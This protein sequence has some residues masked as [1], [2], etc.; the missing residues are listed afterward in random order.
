MKAFLI[1]PVAESI[2]EVEYS[3]EYQDIYPLIGAETFDVVTL[4]PNDDSAFIDDEGLL[5]S[6][7]FF[8]FHRNRRDPVAGCGLVLGVDGEGDSI[9]PTVSRE[10]LA[11]DI[12]FANHDDVR[13]VLA[14]QEEISSVFRT[15]FEEVA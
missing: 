12:V 7:E 5:K 9:A 13:A 2:T 8:W 1:D 3:G 4:Y 11:K 15:I 10:Q 14:I 6:P